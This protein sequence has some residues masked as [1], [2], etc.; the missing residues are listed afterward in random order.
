MYDPLDTVQFTDPELRAAAVHAATDYGTYVATHMYNVTG[1]RRAIDAG[2]KSI[3]HG[4]LADEETIALMAEKGIW[5]SMQPFAL[6]DHLY[7]DPVR[8]ER[9]ARSVPAPM[10][11]I[12]ARKHGVKTAWGTDLLLDPQ[13]TPRQ[14][15]MAARLGEHYSDAEALTM[16]ASGDAE[17]FR[18][19]GER[20]PYRQTPFGVIAKGAWADLL[21]LERISVGEEEIRSGRH[22]CRP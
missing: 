21:L 19:A 22:S 9:I 7:P 11:S 16:L 17:L 3:E 8:A 20:D 5:L 4:H 1:I 15:E 14:S 18:L 10:T 13:L 6:G 2:V 12:W